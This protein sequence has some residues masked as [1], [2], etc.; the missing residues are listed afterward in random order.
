MILAEDFIPTD[1]LHV[2][3]DGTLGHV[4]QGLYISNG[5]GCLLAAID[6]LQ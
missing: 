6:E 2:A 1:L 4:A 3:D 5:Q